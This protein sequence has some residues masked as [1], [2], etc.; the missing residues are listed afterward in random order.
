MTP[1]GLVSYD[2]WYGPCAANSFTL[3]TIIMGFDLFSRYGILLGGDHLREPNMR[4]PA[5]DGSSAFSFEMVRDL[6]P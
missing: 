6:K 3:A 4:M 2:S 5:L 1:G